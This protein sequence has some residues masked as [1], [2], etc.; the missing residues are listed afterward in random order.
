MLA[1]VNNMFN[2][3]SVFI[4]TTKNGSY[5]ITQCAWNFNLLDP[6]ELFTQFKIVRD[7]LDYLLTIKFKIFY[8]LSNF[9]IIYFWND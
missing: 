6:E 5:K 8:N 4:V 1:V 3:R 7:K 2:Y 9:L